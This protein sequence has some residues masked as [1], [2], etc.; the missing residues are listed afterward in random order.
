MKHIYGLQKTDSICDIDQVLCVLRLVPGVVSAML[1]EGVPR[2]V[3]VSDTE[4][5]IEMLNEALAAKVPCRLENGQIQ[6]E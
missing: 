6:S 4:V 1:L 2:V 5:P 3:I